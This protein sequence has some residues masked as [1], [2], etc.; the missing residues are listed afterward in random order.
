[1]RDDGDG[2]DDDDEIGK[3]EPQASSS[4]ELVQ[5]Y[6]WCMA[7]S[8]SFVCIG[9]CRWNGLPSSLRSMILS[10]IISSSFSHLKPSF[11]LGV[12]RTGSAS[13]KLMLREALYKASNT[14]QYVGEPYAGEWIL[15]AMTDSSLSSSYLE[16]HTSM[17]NLA[18]KLMLTALRSNL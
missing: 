1:M 4:E 17:L 8:R 2:D 6:Y 12:P 3:S 7:Q 15:P 9:A 16:H 5:D 13:E 18:E 14:I 11:F 10:G